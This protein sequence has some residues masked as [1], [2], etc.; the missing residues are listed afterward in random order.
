[1]SCMEFSG[2]TVDVA[3]ALQNS[4]TTCTS[5]IA[6]LDIHECVEGPLDQGNSGIVEQTLQFLLGQSLIGDIL[7]RAPST[8][9][10][11]AN[12]STDCHSSSFGGTS[13][14][15]AFFC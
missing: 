7:C 14:A 6:R 12:K 8:M 13:D 1:M 2:E 3:V 11:L 15:F 10:A 5:G 4:P 9:K